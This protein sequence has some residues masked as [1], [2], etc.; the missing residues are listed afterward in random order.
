M[1]KLTFS[2]M[3]DSL[4]AVNPEY[5]AVEKEGTF[6]VEV[7]TIVARNIQRAAKYLIKNQL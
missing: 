4:L 1:S 7:K 2:A 3:Q 6:V 5:H